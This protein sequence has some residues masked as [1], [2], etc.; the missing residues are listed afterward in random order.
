MGECYANNFLHET[1]QLLLGMG[2]N[3][4]LEKYILFKLLEINCIYKTK[5]I[6]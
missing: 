3:A 6:L 4:M 2:E 5:I 1:P